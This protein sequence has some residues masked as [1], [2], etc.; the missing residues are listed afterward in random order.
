MTAAHRRRGLVTEQMVCH[1]LR[2]HGFPGAERSVRTGYRTASR[3]L[4]D[5]ADV[6]L[7]PGV[8]AQVK[9]LSPASR[10]ER[11]VPGWMAETEAQRVA[12]AADVALLIVRRP[13]TADVGEWF[14]YLPVGAVTVLCAI[15]VGWVDRCRPEVDRSGD[16]WARLEMAGAAYLLRRA[17][18][19]DELPG[20]GS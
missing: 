3:E 5:A 6:V 9:S 16:A 12:A 1:W 7:C 2:A 4:P 20:G 18:Y 19:G 15:P 8:I 10:A 14:A 11:A 13:G 17:G